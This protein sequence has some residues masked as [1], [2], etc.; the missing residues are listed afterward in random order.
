MPIGAKIIM[1]I[2]SFK[3]KHYPDGS[4]NKHKAC[5]CLY[6]HCG[7]QTMGQDYWETHALVVTWANVWLLLI[8]AKI[9]GLSYKSINCVLTFP[10]AK[11]DVPN[12]ME[13]PA[14]ANPVNVNDDNQHHYVLK[15]NK[16]SMASNKLATIGLKSFVK[17][18]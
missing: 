3:C 7:L 12:Y 5:L 15:L 8:V 1:A 18:W 14:G 17:D 16:V 2:W 13:F 10:Q 4:L 9:H 11:L 6:A